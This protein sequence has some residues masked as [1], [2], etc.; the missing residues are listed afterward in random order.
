[1]DIGD[2]LYLI[3]MVVALVASIYKKTKSNT[4]GGTII[5][6][7]EV[8]DPFDEVFPTY[9]PQWHENE[10]TEERP[11]KHPPEPKP[12]LQPERIKYQR[13]EYN[14]IRKTDRIKRPERTTR[15]TSRMVKRKSTAEV[16]DKETEYFWDE[17]PLDLQNAII[18]SEIIKRP[19][20]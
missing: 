19:D 1:M 2:V 9:N 11:Q 14:R 18:Y 16:I 12:A 4:H 10:V 13:I 7:R 8:G 15:L 3:V 20:Y 5:P 17:K 6:E